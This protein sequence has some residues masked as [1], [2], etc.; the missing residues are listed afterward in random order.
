MRSVRMEI[1]ELFCMTGE[2][3]LWVVP[4]DTMRWPSAV[5]RMSQSVLALERGINGV[6]SLSWFSAL[7]S[8]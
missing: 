4:T 3:K 1:L 7:S 6:R 8:G 5:V 2:D